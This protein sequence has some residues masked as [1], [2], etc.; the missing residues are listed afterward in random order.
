[1]G[2][3]SLD[4]DEDEDEIEIVSVELGK[5]DQV[6]PQTLEMGYHSHNHLIK[7]QV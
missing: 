6:Y 4:E 2:L 3:L 7:Y 1:M 5:V